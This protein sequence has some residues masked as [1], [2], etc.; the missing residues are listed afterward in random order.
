MDEQTVTTAEPASSDP[1]PPARRTE[2]K[3][4]KNFNLGQASAVNTLYAWLACEPQYGHREPPTDEEF[5]NA[6]ALLAASAAA[7]YD[8]GG[9][10]AAQMRELAARMT[11]DRRY[12]YA[13]DRNRPTICGETLGEAMDNASQ[14]EGDPGFRYVRMNAL[15]G[16]VATV[17]QHLV[18][19]QRAADAA[20]DD[21]ERG[22]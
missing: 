5:V 8:G 4:G 1:T 13:T 11:L 2:P 22:A 18:D 9:V 7:R 3:V 14:H 15:E 16:A 12:G 19:E 17:P 21:A 10:T 6:L 20:A